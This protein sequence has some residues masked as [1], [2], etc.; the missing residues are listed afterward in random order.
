[1]RHSEHTKATLD[2]LAPSIIEFGQREN[3]HAIQQQF[4]DTEK[5]AVSVVL[6][7]SLS[8]DCISLRDNY[9]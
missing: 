6:R 1:M 3:P 8:L 4:L 9:K 2:K 5:V 7:P